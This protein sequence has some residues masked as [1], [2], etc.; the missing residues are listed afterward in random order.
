MISKTNKVM[1]FRKPYTAIFLIPV[2][3]T[4]TS[5]CSSVPTVKKIQL[6]KQSFVP[7][8]LYDIFDISS[9]TGTG[10]KIEIRPTSQRDA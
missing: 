5:A 6:A 1:I 10:L 7:E 2:L 3:L 4:I 8:R 9:V